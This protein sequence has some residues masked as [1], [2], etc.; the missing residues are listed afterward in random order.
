MA[1]PGHSGEEGFKIFAR[2]L[3]RGP[4]NLC[5]LFH[6]RI[7]GILVIEDMLKSDHDR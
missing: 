4:S 7:E 2:C 3:L 1:F 5:L 6:I